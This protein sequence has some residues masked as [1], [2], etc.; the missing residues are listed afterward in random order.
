MSYNKLMQQTT[1]FL[2]NINCDDDTKNT[3]KNIINQYNDKVA[4]DGRALRN[5]IVTKRQLPNEL[6]Y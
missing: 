5:L 3:I 2:K 4:A 1:D 6:L